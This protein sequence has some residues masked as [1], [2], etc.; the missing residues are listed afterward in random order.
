MF[1]K[2][3]NGPSKLYVWLLIGFGLFLS[4]KKVKTIYPNPIKG[5]TRGV[6]NNNPGNLRKSAT[7]W[8]G[9]INPSTDPAFEQFQ[10][11]EYGARASMINARTW[12]NR[13]LNTIEKLI[14]KWAPPSENDT[15]SY[16]R[17][18]SHFTGIPRSSVFALTPENLQ[19]IG[20]AIAVQEN[21]TTPHITR[22]HYSDAYEII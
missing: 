9:K 5:A 14:S 6:K 21:G 2:L 4:M 11:M 22:Q 19:A 13:G 3:F 18:V 10:S 1:S 7:R 12:Y 8:L 17:F 16:I 20:Y 15:E